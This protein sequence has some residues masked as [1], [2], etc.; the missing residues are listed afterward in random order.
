MKTFYGIKTDQTQ[1]FDKAGRRLFITKI[2]TKPAT[3]VQV[4]K[5]NKDGYSA[6]QVGLGEKKKVTKPIAG[7]LKKSGTKVVRWLREVKLEKEDQIKV[8]DK[9]SIAQTFK[10]GDI[11]QVSGTTKGKGFAGAMKRWG[12][13]G[14]PRT[15]GQSDRQRAPGSIGGTTDPG[16][17]WPGKKMPGHM[18]NVTKSI[19]G[20]QIVKINEKDQEIW[21]T[22]AIPGNRGGLLKITKIGEKKFVGLAEEKK[23]SFTKAT[24]GQEKM[25]KV[26]RGKSKKKK[27]T[28]K[29]HEKDQE[30]KKGN[31]DA[32]S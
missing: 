23:S 15:H 13:A 22:G 30:V 19:K 21:V 12:F 17:V 10:V 31:K 4:K 25:E 1:T 32:K 11:V 7:H 27:E 6:V 14:G 28:S 29:K 8:G 24:E 3:V 18:G 20:L 5:Q 2:L 9:I 26:E 16:R